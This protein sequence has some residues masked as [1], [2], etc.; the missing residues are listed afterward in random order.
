[1]GRFDNVRH[2]GRAVATGVM[3]TTVLAVSAPASSLAQPVDETDSW[4]RIGI[5]G[6]S[7]TRN[8]SASISATELT[9]SGGSTAAP[10]NERPREC[11]VRAW[12]N[13]TLS[14][15]RAVADQLATTDTMVAGEQY[16]LECTYLDTGVTYYADVF[17]YEPGVSGPDLDAIAR[18]V[19]DEVPL[20]F[21]QPRTS[22]AIDLDQ[23]VGLTTWLW[24]DPAGFQTFDAHVTLAGITVTVTAT[25]R[26]VTWDLGDGTTV[27][28]PGPGTPYDPARGN[29]QT[30]DCSHVYRYVSADQPDG[31]YHASVTITWAVAWS[32]STGEGGPLPDAQRTTTFELTATERQA[33]VTYGT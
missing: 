9:A 12:H 33:V 16:Y 25:P 15:T 26:H 28:C 2:L 30:T 14:A 27:V 20:V 5:D 13:D 23:L 32:S 29:Q 8:P 31:R 19:Y 6:G 10:A 22:P 4:L 7:D 24:I 18:Q 3:I 21:P 1:M 17:T 11:L